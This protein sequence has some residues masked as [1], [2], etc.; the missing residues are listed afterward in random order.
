MSKK[1]AYQAE[2][3]SSD[4]LYLARFRKSLLLC[5]DVY[6]SSLILTSLSMKPTVVHSKYININPDSVDIQKADRL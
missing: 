1:V 6:S 5:W 2:R 3:F 4:D